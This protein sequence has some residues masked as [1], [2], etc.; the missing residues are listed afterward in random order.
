MEWQV[1]WLL[2]YCLCAIVVQISLLNMHLWIRTC[3]IY[4][5]VCSQIGGRTFLDN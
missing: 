5:S 1:S 2:L 4:D 3:L